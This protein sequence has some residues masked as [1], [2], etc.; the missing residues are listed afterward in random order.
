MLLVCSAADAT[1]IWKFTVYWTL[2]LEGILFAACGSWAGLVFVRRSKAIAPF[3]I[4][5]PFVIVLLSAA[6]TLL[7]ATVVGA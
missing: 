2:L 3:A 1:A 5:I 6:W 4:I 7:T